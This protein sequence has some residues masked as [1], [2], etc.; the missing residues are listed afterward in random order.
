MNPA[1]TSDTFDPLGAARAVAVWRRPAFD[2]HAIDALNRRFESASPADIVR[3]AVGQFGGRLWLSASFA[4]TLLIDIATGIEP[5]VDVVFL[6]TG[7]HFAETLATVRRAMD[8]YSL[9]LT[10]LRPDHDAVD[11]WAAG[12]ERCCAGRKT[13]PLDRHLRL[14]ADAW[15]PGLRRA[16][17]PGRAATPIVEID[18]RGLVKINPLATMTDAAVDRYMADHDIIVNPLAFEGYASIGCWPCTEPSHDGRA[19]RWTGSAKT[20]CGLHR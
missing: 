19:G 16:D 15:L 4:D 2:R 6:D 11:V 10:V 1:P 20:E 14:H 9:A 5:D 8:R 12:A 17:S 3:W 18:R 7:F 13:E